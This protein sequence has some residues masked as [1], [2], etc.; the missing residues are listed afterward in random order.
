MQTFQEQKSAALSVAQLY[1]ELQSA[2]NREPWQI[3]DYM[4]GFVGDVGKLSKLIM[5]VEGRRDIA[6]ADQM[7]GHELA[8]CLWSVIV[9]AEKLGV[10]LP[11]EFNATMDELSVSI[12]A[13]LMKQNLK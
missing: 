8:D 2:E 3:M 10:D 12:R 7:I 9:I 4:A 11:A 1:E 13:Q 5:A 6:N